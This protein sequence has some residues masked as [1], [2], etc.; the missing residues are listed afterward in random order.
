MRILVEQ[1]DEQFLQQMHR[2]GHC[3]IQ[4]MC[5]ATHVTAT[6]VRQRLNRLQSLGLVTR[7]TVKQ[8]RGRPHHAYVVTELGL[9]QLGDNY[10]EL[11]LLLWN[12][13]NHME[14][15]SVR[16]AVMG[17][18][19]DA[20][21][22]RYGAQVVG[23]TL[24]E[25]LDQ[26]RNALEERGFHVE[27][28]LRDGLPILRENHCPYPELAAADRGICDLEQDVFS[29]ILG[30]P[31]VLSQCCRDGHPSCEFRPADCGAEEAVC[32]N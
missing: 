17:R 1:G 12:E 4:E 31:M 9:K 5:E 30:V 15:Q 6:A 20:L 25:R 2:L 32:Q 7:E 24:D 21:S 27:L 19:R 23:R 16:Q 13:L 14:D 10:G 29:R 3:S 8:G 26:L 18:I 28:A 22:R 11:A